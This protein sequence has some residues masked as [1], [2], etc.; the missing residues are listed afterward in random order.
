MNKDDSM[1]E[2]KVLV[3][4]QKAQDSAEHYNTMIWTLVSLGFALSLWIINN[5]Y[6]NKSIE[7]DYLLLTLFFGTF[8]LAYFSKLVE[9]ANKNK[10]LKYDI[11]KDIEEKY[12]FVGKQHIN[13]SGS[14]GIG[15]FRF[16]TLF[17]FAGYF[18]TIFLGPF[19]NEKSIV[20]I[21][22]AK[23]ILMF[24]FICFCIEISFMSQKKKTY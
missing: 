11:C 3:E 7:P 8:V 23:G 16:I 18:A 12:G 14:S 24:S 6:T 19:W 10:N 21:I 22:W 17:I 1:I 20:Q 15:I 2:Q 4:Y 5:F 9:K 13:T